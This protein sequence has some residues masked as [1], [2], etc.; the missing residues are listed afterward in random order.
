MVA[1]IVL[2]AHSGVAVLIGRAGGAGDGD[3]A[4]G[5]GGVLA[6]IVV[7]IRHGDEQSLHSALVLGEQDRDRGLVS[8]VQ[9]PAVG[10]AD[11]QGIVFV[12]GDGSIGNGVL[13]V[14]IRDDYQI[15]AHNGLALAVRG[16]LIIDFLDFFGFQRFAA[17]LALFMLA[18][19]AVGGRLLVDDPVAGLVSGSVGVVAL[20]GVAAADTGVGGVA[21]L[22]AGGG[23]HFLCIVMAQSVFND[24]A[25]AGAE[26]GLGA[27]G[28]IAGHM[29][30]GLVALQTGGPAADAG[31][32]GHALA[33]AGGPGDLLAL[34]PT[35]A[36]RVGVVGD[37]RTSTALADM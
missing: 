12:E 21:H 18:A 35:V 28:R 16:S 24:S 5:I 1:V 30:C 33:G 7:L 11:R 14:G 3:L 13:G 9:N 32:L 23:S 25:A 15:A 2:P 8:I 20:V 34:V 6:V 17:D 31:V 19:L 22:R 36:Q 29:A 37:K 26:L 27:G 10:E 4:A